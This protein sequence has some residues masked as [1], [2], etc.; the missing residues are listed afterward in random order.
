MA[1]HMAVMGRE[2]PAQQHGQYA[3][4]Q[5]AAGREHCNQTLG[6]ADARI[7]LGFKSLLIGKQSRLHRA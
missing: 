2:I 3:A 7:G 6:L 5:E 4:Q 1:L